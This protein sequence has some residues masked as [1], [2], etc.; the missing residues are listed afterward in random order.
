MS[1]L[2]PLTN[3]VSSGAEASRVRFRVLALISSLSVLTYLDRIC[4]QTVKNDVKGDLGLTDVEI[5]FVFSAFMV[6]YAIFEIPV[7][8]LSDIFGARKIIL[9]IVLWWSLFTALTG[10]VFNFFP[11]SQLWLPLPWGWL[12]ISWALASLV[13]V[14]FL[15]G[16]GEAGVYPTL[17]NVVRTWFPL[18]ERALAQGVIMMSNR[19]GAAMAPIFIG[20]LSDIVGWRWVFAILG[21]IGVA[22]AFVFGWVFR[23]RPADHT[24]V[25]L[26][27]LALIGVPTVASVHTGPR[28][29]WRE[30]LRRPTVWAM[31][32]LYFLSIMFGWAF[33]VTWQPTYLEEVYGLSDRVSRPWVG[34]NYV[35]GAAGCLLGGRLS[36]LVLRRTGSV[37][38]A[39]SLVGMTGLAGAGFCFLAASLISWPWQTTVALFAV[40]AFSSDIFLAP[41]WAAISDVGGRFTGTLA[42][43]FNMLALFGV[44]AFAICLPWLRERGLEWHQV[45]Q[46]IACAWLVAAALW[47]IVD[48]GRPL[49]VPDEQHLPESE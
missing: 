8:W 4:I 23:E 11:E 37:R 17:A 16:C 24:Q 26:E 32:M 5:G 33:Y 29:P 30:A 36:D 35:C 28:L 15:F 49:L 47:L 38:W 21:L 3:P 13:L 14:R 48:A 9:R 27:E 7:G 34:L 40:A 45:L 1:L 25:N 46:I 6:G 22:W 20:G 10:A 12:G 43:F 31:G 18:T 41:Y 2:T 39:R 44:S 42:G 19:C